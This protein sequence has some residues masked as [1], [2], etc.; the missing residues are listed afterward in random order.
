MILSAAVAILLAVAGCG[1]DHTLAQATDLFSR[2]D[3]IPPVLLSY[4]AA[5]ASTIRFEFDEPIARSG[6]TVEVDGIAVSDLIVSG[7]RLTVVLPSPME[8]GTSCIV[9]ARIEDETGNS[10]RFSVPVWAKNPDPASLLINEFSTK[11]SKT[12]P[13]R[14]EL[15]TTKSGNLAGLTIANGTFSNWTD[16]C[17]L[18]DRWVW[19]GTYIVVG[20]QEA[21]GT[22]P[23]FLSENLAGLGSNNGCLVLSGNPGADGQILDAV[24]YGNHA[25]TTHEGF[26]S[27]TLQESVSFLAERMMW[28]T[29]SSEG[30][31]DS[32]G[33]TATRTFC[34]DSLVDTN[35][36][37]DWYIVPTRGATFG[38]K[39]TE[40]RYEP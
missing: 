31:V 10:N 13:D 15:V 18:P 38:S 16:R 6:A 40:E 36:C 3:C 33:S 23:D 14:V 39:N 21:A 5:D 32:T 4:D 37:D 9:Q 27:A 35:G 20:F 24:V 26:G 22:E 19:Q 11:G 34:R 7:Q 25:T 12:N 2:H 8:I 1:C 28:D 29:A 17:I 30:S